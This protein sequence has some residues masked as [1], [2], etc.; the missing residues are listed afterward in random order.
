[1][2]I[3]TAKSSYVGSK[4]FAQIRQNCREKIAEICYNININKNRVLADYNS[5]N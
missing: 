5:K 3:I 1:L 2:Q 4:I